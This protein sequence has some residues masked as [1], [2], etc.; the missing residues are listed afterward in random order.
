V[1]SITPRFKLGDREFDFAGSTLEKELVN[2]L[3][4]N[5]APGE[6]LFF[7]YIYDF[8]TWKALELGVPPHLTRLGYLLFSNGFTWFKDW[9]YAEGF[10]EGNP[11]LQ[12]EKPLSE[13]VKTRHIRELCIE[14]SN[15]IVNAKRKQSDYSYHEII[16]KAYQ[17]A[18]F[19]YESLCQ[20][21]Y[22]K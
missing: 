22:I 5:I 21:L 8:E 19:I 7:E 17:R 15:F 2:C 4:K 13:E 10:M 14:T 18:E 16:N 1:F 3:S 6:T 20:G 11:K 12:V 9:Y